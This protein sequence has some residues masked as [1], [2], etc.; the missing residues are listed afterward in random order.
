MLRIPAKVIYVDPAVGSTD[1]T[2]SCAVLTLTFSDRGPDTLLTILIENTTSLGIGST[3]TAFGFELPAGLALSPS[4][5][6]GS[7]SSYFDELTFDHSISPGWL[8]APGGYDLMITSEG[9]FQGG[10]PNGGLVAGE[11]RPWS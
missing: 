11:S 4:F 9:N 5:A 3:V 2:G 6:P 7:P 8:D 10:N 1:N